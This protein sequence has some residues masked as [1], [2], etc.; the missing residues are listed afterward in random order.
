MISSLQTNSDFFFDQYLKEEKFHV[1]EN[2]S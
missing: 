1:S 2:L